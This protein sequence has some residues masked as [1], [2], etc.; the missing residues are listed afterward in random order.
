[1]QYGKFIQ[2]SLMALALTSAM[3]TS[4]IAEDMGTPSGTVQFST[5]SVAAGVGVSWGEGTLSFGG[6]TYPFKIEGLGLVGG[7]AAKVQ[8]T[9]NVYNLGDVADFAGTYK[10][11]GMGLTTGVGGDDLQMKNEKDVTMVISTSNEGVKLSIG[12]GGMKIKLVE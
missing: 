4:A 11:L 7:G 2:S 1:M 5:V 8:A 10:G 6:D 9:G 12:G 3:A